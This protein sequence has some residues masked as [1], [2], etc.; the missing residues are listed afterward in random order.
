MKEKY[1]GGDNP[2]PASADLKI[3]IVLTLVALALRIYFLRFVSVIQTDGAYYGYLAGMIRQGDLKSLLN[4][5]WPP[6]YP[7]LTALAARI[8]GDLELAGCL[9]SA[10]CGG[11]LVPVVYALGF[12]TV[13]KPA[14]TWGACVVL[15]HPRLI[16]YSEL[17]LTESLFVLVFALTLLMIAVAVKKNRGFGFFLCGL[18]LALLYLTRPEGMVLGLAL[19]FCLAVIFARREGRRWASLSRLLLIALGAA[20]LLVPYFSAMKHHTGMISPGEK[21][22]YNFYIT[23]KREFRSLGI[24]IPPAWMNRIPPLPPSAGPH[25]SS[26]RGG[27]S[28]AS[29]GEKASTPY[30]TVDFLRRKWKSV[31]IHMVKTFIINLVDKLPSAFYY[32]LFLLALTGLF[33]P[34]RRSPDEVIWA[35][36]ILAAALAYSVYFPLRRFYL[37]FIPLLSLWAGCGAVY[38]WEKAFRTGVEGG[39][40]AFSNGPFRRGATAG[41]L[42]LWGMVSI[43]YSANSVKSREY[44]LEYKEAG[45]WLRSL[46]APS[47]V[48]GARK[49]E[50]SFYAGGGFVPL[51]HLDPDRLGRW[52]AETG[53]THIFLDE[54]IVPLSHP[55][56]LPVLRGEVLPFGLEVIRRREEGGARYLI[57]APDRD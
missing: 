38:L 47:L 3:V 25:P 56:Y 31:V 22:K 2:R 57:L 45:L 4:P 24:E 20:I 23:Y 14:C 21:A 42:I 40:R 50:I 27:E 55:E 30:H 32:P 52:M 44:P 48:V 37:A 29:P 1:S 7:A 33:I 46:P 5:A 49:P 36:L 9:V 54:R 26:P 43:P 19:F 51:P 11:M 41:L 35:A 28:A 17:F 53:V 34:R 16:V 13:G 12:N 18:L 39:R 15:F 6:L 8:T 10:L